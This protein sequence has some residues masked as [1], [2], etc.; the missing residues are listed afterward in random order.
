MWFYEYNGEKVG[1]IPSETL[2]HLAAHGAITPETHIWRSDRQAPVL[3]SRVKNLFPEIVEAVVA[4]DDATDTIVLYLTAAL[5][6]CR[7]E[8]EDRLKGHAPPIHAI[9][10]FSISEILLD[11]TI[12]RVRELPVPAYDPLLP[13]H[14]QTKPVR[15]MFEATVRVILCHRP[16]Y[17]TTL[18]EIRRMQP[19]RREDI[20]VYECKEFKDGEWIF[21]DAALTR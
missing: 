12:E 17:R 10:P 15:Q 8:D 16:S 9:H 21:L 18:G 4:E 3:A 19:G 7:D 2:K 13:L 14:Q 6:A 20:V 1:P 11:F 5:N